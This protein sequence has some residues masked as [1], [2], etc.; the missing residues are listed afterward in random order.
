MSKYLS[1]E[2]VGESFERLSS[3]NATGKSHLE[4]TSALMYFLSIDTTFKYLNARGCLDLDP[5]SSEGKNNRKQV[6]LE[7]ARLVLLGK[8]S[9]DKVMQVVELGKIDETGTQ[10]EKRISSNFLTVPLK[11]ASNQTAPF[12]YPSRPKAPLLKMG[13]SATGKRWG[14]GYHEDWAA[15]FLLMLTTV[16][17]KTPLI[18]LAIFICRDCVFDDRTIDI[19][20]A[21]KEQLEKRFTNGIANFWT[22]RI[23]KEKILYTLVDIPFAEQ[24]ESFANFY[25]PRQSGKRYEQMKKSELI[26]RIHELESMLGIIN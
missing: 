16:N 19:F 5:E 25:R 24:K 10:P 18:D 14:I 26:V 22:Q 11:K 6:E 4:R 3:L 13:F 8:T 21:I 20:Q 15:N 1:R 23:E 7:F 17:S 12:Y 2:I 9:D